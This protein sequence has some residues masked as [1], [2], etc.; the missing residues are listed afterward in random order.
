VQMSVLEIHTWNSTADG[1]ENPDRVIFDLDPGPRVAWA[2]VVHGARAIRARV[3]K[4]GFSTFVKTTGGKGLHVVVPLVAD[5]TWDSQFAFAHLV[6]ETLAAEDPA[7]Y[8]T[9]MPKEGREAKI[10]IDFFRN[11]RGATAVAAFSTRKHPQASVSLPVEWDEI[12][13]FSPERQFTVATVP[14]RLAAQ[15]RDPWRDYDQSR[16]SLAQVLAALPKGSVPVEPAAAAP[17]R[18]ASQRRRG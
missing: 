9:S 16:K 11:R 14:A 8:T 10:L 7:R 12:D 1:L 4:L 15:K 18:A 13:D 2:D 6:S 5:S 3:E 17:K